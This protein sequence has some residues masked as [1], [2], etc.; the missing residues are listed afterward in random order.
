MTRGYQNLYIHTLD[1]T[2]EKLQKI[3]SESSKTNIDNFD[4]ELSENTLF[5]LSE[6]NG[7]RQ[8]YSLDLKTKKEKAI[9][10]GA[11]Y[12]NSIEWIDEE[13]Q[14]IYFLASG[15]EKGRNPYYQ[16]LYSISF[17]GENLQLLTPEDR[18]HKISFS[19]DGKYVID[20]YSTVNIPTTST[21]RSTSTGKILMELGRADVKSFK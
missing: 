3:Y 6:K 17:N 11:F 5:F 2:T 16:H 10:N 8:L 19:P 7:W 20:N 4:Y 9:T 14:K 12:V 1:L 18:H 13:N 21:L 15:K